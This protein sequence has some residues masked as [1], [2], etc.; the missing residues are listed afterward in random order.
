L[1]GKRVTPSTD[2]EEEEEQTGGKGGG[3]EEW[4][5][6]RKRRERVKYLN[7][8]TGNVNLKRDTVCTLQ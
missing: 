1:L 2:N 5:E 7:E 8:W 4:K 6:R 3:G